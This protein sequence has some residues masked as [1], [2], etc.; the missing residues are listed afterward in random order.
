[1]RANERVICAKM[2]SCR[3]RYNDCGTSISNSESSHRW[4][5]DA[6]GRHAS[7]TTAGWRCEACHH[8]HWHDATSSESHRIAPQPQ[9][10]VTRSARIDGTDI[11][12]GTKMAT[13]LGMS[14]GDKLNIIAAGEVSTM[15]TITGLTNQ[16]NMN[17]HR[18][19]TFMAFCTAQTLM[20]FPSGV[21]SM[22]VTVH[23]LYETAVIARCIT[24]ANNA[25][26]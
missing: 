12:F 14:A 10:I 2:P 4:E 17:E 13:N 19:S 16:G 18:R 22:D 6:A 15:I 9:R 7:P 24:H 1:M 23:H 20:A 8:A 11:R 3:H 5:R 21:T 26:A 25:K